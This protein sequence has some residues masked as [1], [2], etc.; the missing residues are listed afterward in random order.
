MKKRELLELI[1]RTPPP[2]I[3][4]RQDINHGL[5]TC[6]FLDG[7]QLAAT[8]R[9]LDLIDRTHLKKLIN[10]RLLINLVSLVIIF[11]YQLGD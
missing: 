8:K 1:E 4:M 5:A 9:E 10:K 11:A 7:N 3:K 6:G 2:I